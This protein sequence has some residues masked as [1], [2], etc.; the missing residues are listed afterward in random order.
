MKFNKEAFTI[1][2]LVITMAIMM[3]LAVFAIINIKPG[4]NKAKLFLYSALSN[5]S[6]AVSTIADENGKSLSVAEGDVDVDGNK[7]DW[8]CVK[9][10]DFFS[11]ASSA[12]CSKDASATDVNIVF[13]SGIEIQGLAG[14]WKNDIKN[15]SDDNP[16][17]Y[18]D[19]VIDI[20]GISKGMNKVGVDRF[21][22]RIYKEMIGERVMPV[23]CSQS[24]AGDYCKNG[25]TR[26]D[27]N[28]AKSQDYISFDIYRADSKDSEN[29]NAVASFQSYMQADCG[30]NGGSGYFTNEECAEA[31][32]YLFPKCI[33]KDMCAQCAS[34]ANVCP[35]IAGV[36]MDAQECRSKIDTYNPDEGG[37]I[38][39]LH[40]PSGGAGLIF[41]TMGESHG[42]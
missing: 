40:R 24:T 28:L 14:P 35:M 10:A 2:E 36:Q 12:N 42:N 5:I 30:I 23:D 9:L 38:P 4:Q 16:Y 41:D 21:P 25:A 37:C 11:L 26:V 8:L 1:T 19:F 27:V 18:K 32:Y 13:T 7:F 31:G 6:S 22:M 3:V 34:G 39:L 29:A 20:D 17:R 15:D 33:S